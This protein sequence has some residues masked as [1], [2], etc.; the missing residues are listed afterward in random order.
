MSMLKRNAA[1]VVLAGLV[2]GGAAVAWAGGSPAQPTLLA[3]A[4]TDESAPPTSA[5]ATPP[6]PHTE[7]ERPAKRDAIRACL[8]AAGEDAAA[9]QAC[10]PAGAHGPGHKDRGPGRPGPLGGPGILGKAV[11]GSAVVPGPTEGTWQTVTFDRGKV[12]A[13][14][15]GSKI[16]LA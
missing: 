10:V 1:V 13:A 6:A 7:A 11:H 16:V 3:A 4:Q 2:L 12:E 15:D 5:P 14:T 8:E 9:R